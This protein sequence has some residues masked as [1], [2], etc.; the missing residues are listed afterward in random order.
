[1][2]RRKAWNAD[3]EPLLR[4]DEGFRLDRRRPRRHPG[5]PRPQDRRARV[6]RRRCRPARRPAGT[7]VGGVRP[8]AT[9]AACCWCCRRW[10]PRARAASSRTSSA[11]STRTACTTPASRRRRPRSASTTSSGASSSS[12]PAAGQLGVFDRSHYEDV[13]IQ[14]VRGFAPPE[15][16]ERRYGA[17]I[18]FEDAPRRAGHHHRQGDA[19]HLEGRAARAP[20]RPAR[21]PRQAL[22]VQPGRHRR[23]PALG[24]L[25][26]GVPDRLRPH[27]DRA[28]AP[29]YVVPANRKWYARLAV[30][31]LLLRALEDMHL[32]WPQADFDVAEQR[33]RLAES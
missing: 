30:Q 23:A 25:P 18:D 13:L 10:T 19:A 12:C 11:R 2:S 21:P 17:I 24:R 31:Q 15:E 8:R 16:I 1:M 5:L 6:A 4:V 27:V 3:P 33:Q 14:R 9:S 29:W 28:V 20:R 22:E 32:S 7:P 26:A